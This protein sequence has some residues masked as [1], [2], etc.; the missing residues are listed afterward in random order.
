MAV[1][2]LVSLPGTFSPG[3]LQFPEK[4]SVSQGYEGEEVFVRASHLSAARAGPRPAGVFVGQGLAFRV[5]P[6]EGNGLVSVGTC[7][8]IHVFFTF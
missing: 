2:P 1:N 7:I 8:F 3:F 4:V 5:F 6:K